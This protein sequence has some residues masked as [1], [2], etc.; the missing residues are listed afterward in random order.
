MNDALLLFSVRVNGREAVSREESF[1]A[2]MQ[3]EEK[4]K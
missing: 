4:K 1:L 3:E 2:A